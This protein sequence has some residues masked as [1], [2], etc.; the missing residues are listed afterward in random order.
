MKLTAV[1]L[2]FI[3]GVLIAWAFGFI[4]AEPA[5]K[6]LLAFVCGWNVNALVKW[7]RNR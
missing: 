3:I 2:A 5:W 7:V 6:Y 4:D 1:V